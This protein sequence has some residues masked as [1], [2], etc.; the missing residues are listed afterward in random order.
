MLSISVEWGK[1]QRVKSAQA[2]HKAHF[3]MSE[4]EKSLLRKQ[5][6]LDPYLRLFFLFSREDQAYIKHTNI[7]KHMLFTPLSIPLSLS[8]SLTLSLSLSIPLSHYPSLFLS[9]YPSLFLSLFPSLFLSL[10]PSL[11]PS[12]YPFIHPSLSISLSNRLDVGL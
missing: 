6:V 11:S 12:L 5:E 1:K 4:N 7:C 3:K 8:L 10:Y 9:L 2:I